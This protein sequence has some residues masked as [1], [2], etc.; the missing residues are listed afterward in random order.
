MPY[1]DPFQMVTHPDTGELVH[2]LSVGYVREHENNWREGV[3]NTLE[4]AG[5]TG[6]QIKEAIRA[7]EAITEDMLDDT[8]IALSF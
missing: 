7:G 8:A 5:A 1:P 3:C 4:P 2:G 6:A